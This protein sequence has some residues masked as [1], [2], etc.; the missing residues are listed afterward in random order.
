M[1]EE[2]NVLD[3]A[4]EILQGLSQ[5]VL[6][7]TKN[8]EKINTMTIAWG[9]LGIEWDRP[10]FIALVRQS[11]YTHE[12]LDK[13]Q[14]FTISIPFGEIKKEITNFC[15]RHTG[16]NT[17]K[18]EELGLTLEEAMETGVP[19]IKELPLT[20]ECR[21]KYSQ[22]QDLSRIPEDI[23]KRAYPENVKAGTSFGSDATAHTAYYGEIV[24][25]YIIRED[26]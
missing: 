7:T 6:L 23:R 22:N 9:M 17:D 12:I 18:L 13:N 4:N 14:E 10:V 1:K 15:G 19:G 2:I 5:G 16:R 3:Y 8:G 11:R 25:A 20:L 21:V 26:Q 24:R